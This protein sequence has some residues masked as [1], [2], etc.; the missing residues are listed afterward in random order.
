MAIWNVREH[1]VGV[2]MMELGQY[3]KQKME[4]TFWLEE[5]ILMDLVG[6]FI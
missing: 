3:N 1:L 4:D 2:I 5:H 6:M